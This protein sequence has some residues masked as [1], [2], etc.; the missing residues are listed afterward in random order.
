MPCN[1]PGTCGGGAKLVDPVDCPCVSV[2]I[3]KD[4]IS[5]METTNDVLYVGAI[6]NLNLPK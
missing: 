6:C 5:I 3:L 1:S 4:K 2:I